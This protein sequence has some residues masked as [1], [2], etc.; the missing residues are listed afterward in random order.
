LLAFIP[1]VDFDKLTD[2]SIIDAFWRKSVFFWSEEHAR[3]FRAE[4]NQIEGAYYSLEQGMHFTKIV[5][6]GIFGFK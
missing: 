3:E 2:P 1:F 4:T 6:S 5:Q